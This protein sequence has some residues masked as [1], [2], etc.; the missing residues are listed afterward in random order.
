MTWLVAGL[1]ALLVGPLLLRLSRRGRLL[2][3]V[4]GFVVVAIMGLVVVEV[5]P[6]AFAVASGWAVLAALLGLLLPERL[7]GLLQRASRG[8]AAEN[9]HAA[10]LVLGVLGLG[11]HAAMDG[12][13]LHHGAEDGSLAL[14]VIVHRLPVGLAVWWLLEPAHGALRAA[15]ALALVMTGT[16]GG[17]FAAEAADALA[18]QRALGLFEAL[19]GGSLLHVVLHRSFALPMLASGRRWATVGGLLALGTIG[20]TLYGAPDHGHDHGSTEALEVLLQLTVESAPALLLAYVLAGVIA[21][22]MPRAGLRWMAR[23]GVV[24]QAARGVAFGLPIPLCSCGVVPVYRSLV[25][26]GVP[27]AA[28]L[29]FFV[30]TPEI[31]IDAVLLS[32]PLLGADLTIAR[33]VAAFLVAVAVGALVGRGLKSADVAA[34]PA[35]PRIGLREGLR[36]ATHVGLV[37]VVDA[38]A[39]WIAFGLIVAAVAHPLLD[40]DALG[41]VPRAAQVPLLALAGLPVYVCAS[42]ATPLVA[43]MLAHGASPGA[44]LAFLLTGPAT[45]VT[46]FGLLRDLHGRGVALGFGAAVAGAAVVLGWTL[47]AVWPGAQ[48]VTVLEHHEEQGWFG[49]LAAAALLVLF[50]GSVTRMGP[51]GFLTA[52]LPAVPGGGGHGHD[53]A[54]DHGHGHD[55]DHAHDHGHAHDHAHDHDHDHD[56][57]K[58]APRPTEA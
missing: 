10:A 53:H 4:D 32:L 58:H 24:A 26:R 1:L 34:E 47:D 52:V 25:L 2:H 27:P 35:G 18:H 20:A 17:F 39:P 38:T 31:G 9:V 14:A 41:A 50:A 22:W 8:A 30:A 11:L 43:L 56:H 45:N 19:V 33:V 57:G 37:E 51:R 44:A 12:A 46:T 23:G 55:H 40:A 29:G 13:A 21:V 6:H 36:Q 54:H 15:A 16:V 5:L 3:A 42:G 49:L 48:A 28:A 7:E